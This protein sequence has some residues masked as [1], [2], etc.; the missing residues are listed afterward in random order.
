[1]SA[2]NSPAV[3]PRIVQLGGG[4][5]MI[6]TTQ[7]LRAM[8]CELH[9]L[10]RNP[11]APARQFAD[12]FAAVDIADDEGVLNYAR[13]VKADAV[14]PI[15]DAATQAAAFASEA[16]GLPHNSYQTALNATDKGLM[17]TCWA[18][19]GLRQPKFIVFHDMAEL[20]ARAVEIGYPCVLKPCRSW[21]SKGVTVLR[22]ESD[23]EMAGA[24][25]LEHARENRFIIEEYIRGLEMNVEGLVRGDEV[26]IL[27]FGDKVLQDHPNFCVTMQVNYHMPGNQPDVLASEIKE[28]VSNAARALGMRLGALHGEVLVRDG[29]PYLMEMAAR[30]GGGHVFGVIVQEACG[31]PMPETL[32]KL[33]LQQPTNIL[34]KWARGVSYRFFG[35]PVGVFRSVRGIEQA[36][37]RPDVLDVLFDMKPGTVFTHIE[38]GAAR[39]GY[40][41]TT[42]ETRDDAVAVAN[43]VLASL[44][45]EMDPLPEANAP[46]VSPHA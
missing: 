46:F 26:S 24:F 16:L 38:H 6:Q 39:P 20:S 7:R 12:A 45:F 18:N 10:D 2:E 9:V 35:P 42:G 23:C 21:G 15:N 8:G 36:K 11:D 1:M 27:T 13:S 34:P 41:V 31:V 25:A 43:E 40:L 4:L 30:P 22:A 44:Q 19:A 14:L 32:A 28:L 5:L 3:R 33:Y 29:K 17:R 37:Q